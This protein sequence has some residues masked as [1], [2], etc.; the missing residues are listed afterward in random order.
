MWKP[1][2]VLASI[3]LVVAVASATVAAD[4]GRV[5][6]FSRASVRVFD[7]KGQPAGLLNASEV[8]L[9]TPIVAFGVGGSIGINHGGKTVFLRGLDVQTEGVHTACQP[10]QTASRASGT[11]YAGI[12]EGIG[13][14]ADCS[15][16]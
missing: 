11:V 4:L 6:K 2:V 9:P 1:S 5:V 12:N 3:A 13:T 8:R 7:A 15:K 16:R 10:M 14:G